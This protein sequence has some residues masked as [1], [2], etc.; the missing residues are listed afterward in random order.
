MSGVESQATM[1]LSKLWK[2]NLWTTRSLELIIKLNNRQEN[3]FQEAVWR[4]TPTIKMD[5]AKLKNL[6]VKNKTIKWDTVKMS[7]QRIKMY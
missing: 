2:T 5:K 6:K 4:T 3:I 7:D 1:L